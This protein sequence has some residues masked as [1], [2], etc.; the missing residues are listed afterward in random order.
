[1]HSM[2]SAALAQDSDAF[3]QFV[4]YPKPHESFKGQF[5]AKMANAMGKSSTGDNDVA[6]AGAAT[7]AALGMALVDRM[8]DA[9]VRPEMVM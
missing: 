8:I 9:M 6:K 2:R 1:M 4:V 5:G 3:N 7:G